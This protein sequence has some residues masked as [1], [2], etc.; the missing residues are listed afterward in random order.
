VA[1]AAV[2]WQRLGV[3]HRPFDVV[4][5]GM[6]EDGHFASLFPGDSASERGLDLSQPPGCIAVH[7][8]AA[9]ALRV[10]LNLSALLQARQLVLLVT[11]ERKWQLL[12]QEHGA[13][14]S[15]HLPIHQLLAQRHTPVTVYWSP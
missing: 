5:L 14:T 4:V 6:G 12:R 9:P 7:A 8:P 1:G 2:A 11:G 15:L 13:D 3:I 10:S